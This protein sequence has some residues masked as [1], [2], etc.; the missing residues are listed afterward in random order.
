MKYALIYHVGYADRFDALVFDTIEAALDRAE[1]DR[2]KRAQYGITWW[3]AEP[4][5][6]RETFTGAQTHEPKFEMKTESESED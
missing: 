5:E 4:M 1:S 6:R 2:L 3:I